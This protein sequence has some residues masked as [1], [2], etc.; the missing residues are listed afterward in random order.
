MP[1][2][3]TSGD[4]RRSFL[5]D[6]GA[7]VAAIM[8][9]GQARGFSGGKSDPTSGDL[10]GAEIPVSPSAETSN[11]RR[12]IDLSGPWRFQ[13][14][15][16]KEGQMMGYASMDFPS[17]DW[18][19]VSIPRAF[20]DCAP[21]MYKFRGVCWFLRHFEVPA[22][23]KG[24]RVALR[25]EGANYN[26]SVWLNGELV[27]E[28]AD[29][30]LPFEFRVDELLRFGG[31]NLIAVRVDNILRPGQLPTTEYW[32]GQGGI[33]RE[34]KLVA[35]DPA[36]LTHVGIVAAPETDKG[37]LAL[38]ASVANGRL[39]LA[40]LAL[41]VTILN[42]SGQPVVSFKAGPA[43]V[44]AGK[45]A[46]LSVQG[47]V[48]QVGAWSPEQPTL[49]AARV[50]L[51]ADG[52]LVDQQV[53]QFGFRR[54]EA[55]NGNLWLNG[56][57]LFLMG[58]D[59]HEDSPR[60]GMAVDLETA[61]QDFLAIKDTGANFVRFCHYPHHPG[62]LDLCDELGLLVLSEIPLCAWGVIG[63]NFDPYSGGGWNPS[64][65]PTIV[66]NAERQ[67]RKMIFR[68]LNHPS[69]IFWSVSNE[70]EEQHP[71]VNQAN[72]RLIKL[73]RQL[74]PTRL[75]THV[76]EEAHW[77]TD[78]GLKYFEFDD[79]ICVNGYPWMHRGPGDHSWLEKSTRWWREELA[80]LHARCPDKPIV[81][82]EF[83]Y[84]SIQGVNGP[85][86]EDTQVL[87]TI[88]DFE[89]MTEPYVC[90][91]T[92]WCF[93]KH[94]WAPASLDFQKTTFDVGPYGYVSRDRKTNMKGFSIVSR[95]FKQRAE[96]LRR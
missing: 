65:V 25:F 19:E 79:V 29:A 5:K 93:A 37:K 16:W 71:E 21:G 23:M 89:G 15:P 61:R 96:L 59:R 18:C 38:R 68:D 78:K 47:E 50:D 1:D 7:S 64:D 31:Q 69:I 49:Y 88:A 54:I 85:L 13:V 17:Q 56:K 87:A 27:G 20:D 53:T 11:I 10:G 70:S 48:P 77:S 75:A 40:N 66:D 67:L 44:D 86:G 55:R 24:R 33:L 28:N 90:G 3:K 39:Q 52:K 36:R 82:T 74:D 41:Q 58:F 35:T 63:A 12:E 26:T 84:P 46:E 91:A 72:N 8:G 4:T 22:T 94:L 80:R 30:F 32:Q 92:L 2:V 42:H 81:I 45:E 60:T 95:M 76:S 83:G 9:A 57:A 14:D 6:L 62:E 73:A 51:L 34:V 43:A